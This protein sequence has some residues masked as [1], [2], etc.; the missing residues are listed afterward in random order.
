MNVPLRRSE[1]TLGVR[2]ECTVSEVYGQLLC[3]GTVSRDAVSTVC[4]QL[5]CSSA[6]GRPQTRMHY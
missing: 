3:N 1:Q 4:S 6:L 5:Q 2:L